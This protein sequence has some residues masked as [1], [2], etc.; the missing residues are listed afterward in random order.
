MTTPSDPPRA[1]SALEEI[2]SPGA[3]EI[4][5]VVGPTAS[6]KTSLAIALAARFDAEIVSA[7]SVQIYRR[8]DA[9]SGKPSAEELARARHH[10]I[11]AVDP[12]DK[13]D[14]A[15][16]AGLADGAIADIRAR[17]KAVIVCGGTFLW[18]KALVQGLAPL[19]PS[20]DE[21][22]ARHRAIA[23]AEGRA[24]LHALLLEVDPAS[25][26]RLA[27]NDLVR[28]S[29]ALE[30]FELTGET[31]SARHDAHGFR[32]N[33]YPYRLL[34]P[35]CTG[36]ELDVAVAKRVDAFFAAGWIEE[37]EGLVADGLG[38]A[39]AMES[40]GYRQVAAFVAAGKATPIDELKASIVRATRV[41]AMRQRTWLRDAPIDDDTP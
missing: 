1:T 33:R 39:R 9:G 28:V 13:M 38:R 35:R 37:V 18:V 34:R 29:R 21:I 27:P 19:A 6:G 23:E 22:R 17:G 5:V 26:A 4:L 2:P 30:V 14:A 15:I 20:S 3:G 36:A 32:A 8:F 40:V 24:R 10:L 41:F 11:G 7:D 31:L 25:A 12:L 16:F